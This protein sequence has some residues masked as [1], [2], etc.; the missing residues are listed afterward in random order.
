M[1]P[2]MWPAVL[3]ALLDAGAGDAWL[4]PITMKKGRPA[5]TIGAITSTEAAPRVRDTL[6][7]QTTTIGLRQI[8]VDKFALRREFRTIEVMGQPISIKLAISPAGVVVNASAEWDDVAQ[9]AASTAT[10][11][12]RVLAVANSLAAQHVGEMITTKAPLA[13]EGGDT[14]EFDA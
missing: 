13:G 5:H 4:T 12:K 10:P 9:V 14:R 1:D 6:F 7:A 11:V 2:R 8:R 3:A